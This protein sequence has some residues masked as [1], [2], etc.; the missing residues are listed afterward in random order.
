MALNPYN[1]EN[2]TY[3]PVGEAKRP[4]GIV[5]RYKSTD[6]D[7]EVQGV[8]YALLMQ[9]AK[10]DGENAIKR[11]QQ[12]AKI[13]YEYTV[14]LINELDINNSVIASKI[15]KAID[16]KTSTEL[17]TL[18]STGD[19]EE[20]LEDVGETVR[21]YL[22]TLIKVANGS[23]VTIG[24]VG[25]L[26]NT[27]KSSTVE[28]GGGES[29]ETV[30]NEKYDDEISESFIELVRTSESDSIAPKADKLLASHSEMTVA[31]Q[32]LAINAVTYFNRSVTAFS[33][34]MAVASEQHLN[35]LKTSIM[36]FG[37]GG[38][39]AK[40]STD[41]AMKIVKRSTTELDPS[42]NLQIAISRL[43]K[44]DDFEK[45]DVDRWL[46]RLEGAKKELAV[47]R[48]VLSSVVF[49]PVKLV[50]SL[51]FGLEKYVEK[52]Y[53]EIKK[54]GFLNYLFSFEGIVV[55]GTLG[56]IL[57][58]TVFKKVKDS[59]YGTIMNGV[60]KS[61]KKMFGIDLDQNKNEGSFNLFSSLFGNKNNTTPES[62]TQEGDGSQGIFGGMFGKLN[63]MFSK[64]EKNEEKNKMF[65]WFGTLL[66]G[67]PEDEPDMDS[68]ERLNPLRSYLNWTIEEG[69]WEFNTIKTAVEERNKGIGWLMN[70]W[71]DH[72]VENLEKLDDYINKYSKQTFGMSMDEWFNSLNNEQDGI[73]DKK[74]PDEKEGFFGNLR[75][76]MESF[77]DVV[78][79]AIKR[80]PEWFSKTYL[81]E[82][83]SSGWNVISTIATEMW[84]KYEPFIQ[85]AVAVSPFVALVTYVLQSPIGMIARSIG[86][87]GR[88]I[89]ALCKFDFMKPVLGAISNTIKASP[90]TG[91]LIAG[92]ALG[93]GVLGVGIW[94]AFHKVPKS[95]SSITPYDHYAIQMGLAKGQEN[96]SVA[97]FRFAR[98]RTKLIESG[99]ETS[100]LANAVKTLG[101]GVT[102]FNHNYNDAMS[103]QDKNQ[104]GTLHWFILNRRDNASLA[105]SNWGEILSELS[106]LGIGPGL[107][108]GDL[109]GEFRSRLDGKF[110]GRD[111][112]TWINIVQMMKRMKEVDTEF[113]KYLTMADDSQ[114]EKFFE[115]VK[116]NK[117]DIKNIYDWTHGENST[118]VDLSKQIQ[119][120]FDITE[121]MSRLPKINVTSQRT[122]GSNSLITITVDG[123]EFQFEANGFQGHS[124]QQLFGGFA[125]NTR[126][127][128]DRGHQSTTWTGINP[129]LVAKAFINYMQRPNSPFR[130]WEPWKFS[131]ED[132]KKLSVTAN[133][134]KLKD[135]VGQM[136]L[137]RE[138]N[139]QNIA[140]EYKMLSER[141]AYKKLPYYDGQN[142]SKSMAQVVYILGAI[143]K[144][145][146]EIQ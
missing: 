119:R 100:S 64:K 68:D 46:L 35:K 125:K 98:M 17:K 7:Q 73:T 13:L 129:T 40:G 135:I 132:V 109:F 34:K 66:T 136:N 145:C 43:I 45:R 4:N 130:S 20:K 114:I 31:L 94:N 63:K 116:N 62:N 112:K 142:D 72:G 16:A 81:G 123:K 90:L 82:K 18:T 78:K 101:E 144:M 26:K 33:Q 6:L 1:R 42:T 128:G 103:N 76:K 51:F 124:I 140:R 5:E 27:N 121:Q 131:N 87:L 84:K 117:S 79:P 111:E 58:K 69:K 57:Y 91:L 110:S 137:K 105:N 67:A 74:T 93:L 44:N 96:E 102:K 47:A 37:S 61:L 60:K 32:K 48:S 49:A 133:D 24:Q 143:L 10:T 23:L 104:K 120:M 113:R 41:T 108:H 71:T 92:I 21:E 25:L 138:I 3:M 83:I 141:E 122:V 52:T 12:F 97:E 80:I 107:V 55:F 70:E 85:V 127:S 99:D 56:Y 95:D 115:Y 126:Q 54:G 50:S 30:V 118:N 36:N 19:F 38:I 75:T 59:L 77:W 134:F 86:K 88:L 146:D 65:E 9:Y 139:V 22:S 28:I 15:V 11:A 29:N 106:I 8:I 53:K 2:S 89:V 39:V 14:K